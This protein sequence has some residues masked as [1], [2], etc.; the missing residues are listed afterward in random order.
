MIFV[1]IVVKTLLNKIELTIWWSSGYMKGLVIGRL[2]VR[3]TT[4][5]ELWSYKQAIIKEVFSKLTYVSNKFA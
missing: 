5:P 4:R 3:N 1:T 2:Q